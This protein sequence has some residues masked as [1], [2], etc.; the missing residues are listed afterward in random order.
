MHGEHSF[1]HPFHRFGFVGLDGGGDQQ[2]IIIQQFQP[3]PSLEPTEPA[4][5][6]IYVRPRWV[7]GGFGVEVLEPGYWT[8]PKQA[9][10]Q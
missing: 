6:K 8:V 7:D 9:P 2:I 1:S 3:A 10:E 5:N 4:K